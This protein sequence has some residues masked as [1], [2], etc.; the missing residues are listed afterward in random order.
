AL[1][2]RVNIGIRTH[3]GRMITRPADFCFGSSSVLQQRSVAGP[4]FH[5]IAV[6]IAAMPMMPALCQVQTHAA[7]QAPYTGCKPA[8]FG[9]DRKTPVCSSC[10][11]LF[12]TFDLPGSPRLPVDGG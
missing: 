9:A 10:C 5:W 4:L 6:A 3:P 11:E 12:E 7:Q 8:I 1:Q 2:H